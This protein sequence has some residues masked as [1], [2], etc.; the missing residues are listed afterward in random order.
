ML[1]IRLQRVGRKNDPSFRLIAND[2]RRAAK[3]GRVVEVLGAY[4]ARRGQPQ[5]NAERVK[6]WLGHGARC[7][8]TAHNLLVAKKIITAPKIKVLPKKKKVAALAVVAVK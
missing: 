1:M 8:G 2:A 3:A 7:S 4:D 6:Y 5:I